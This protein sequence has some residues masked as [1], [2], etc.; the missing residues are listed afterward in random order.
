MS[1]IEALDHV[2][3]VAA[4]LDAAVL[5]Y[6]GLLGRSAERREAVGGAGRAWFQLSNTALEI[7]APTG[8]G[9][10][11][12]R[13]RARLDAGGEGLWTI[14][15]AVADL[16]EA[17]RTLERRAVGCQPA[18]G[19][20]APGL[21]ADP[22]ATHGVSIAFVE[23]SHGGEPSLSP[24]IGAPA[25]ALAGLDHVVINTPDPERAA[26]LYGA[27]LGLDLRL[28][29]SN[30]DWGSRLLFFRCGDLVV[31]VG[32][33]LKA[34]VSDGPDRLGGL[35]WR[36]ADPAAVQARLAAADFDVSP[37]RKGRKPGTQVFTVRSPTCGV[38][39]LVLS[40]TRP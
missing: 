22:G 21:I 18:K 34:G 27:R 11:G 9:G 40:A 38:P 8:P 37:V 10:A 25:A 36:A 5:A 6:E 35:A 2:A 15:F 31:E 26:A 28:D 19:A 39:T 1:M 17:Q 14:A 13:V 32:H 33:G 20:E 7:I 12:D 29:R 3:L 23:R 4:D 16:A 24:T 30:P